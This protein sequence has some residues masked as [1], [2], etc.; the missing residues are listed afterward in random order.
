MLSGG[1]ES[2]VMRLREYVSWAKK[3]AT[4]VSATVRVA[5]EAGEDLASMTTVRVV[6]GN[7]AGD[8]DSMACALV[9]AFYTYQPGQKVPV[10]PVLNVPR[11]ELRLRRDILEVFAVASLAIDELLFVEEVP[12]FELANANKL[13]LTLVDHNELSPRQSNLATAIRAIVDHHQDAALYQ[14][15]VRERN[16]LFPVGSCASLVTEAMLKM[17]RGLQL[18]GDVAVSLLLRSTIMLDT[19][20][21]KNHKTTELDCRMLRAHKKT[22]PTEAITGKYS[23][24]EWH[25]RIKSMRKDIRGFT[26]MDLV[27]KD[28]KFA[29][30]DGQLFAVASAGVSLRDMGLLQSAHNLQ[31]FAGDLKS[32]SVQHHL[33][34]AVVLVSCSPAN[35]QMVLCAPQNAW[36]ML[37]GPMAAAIAS[38]TQYG[39]QALAGSQAEWGIP[40]VGDKLLHE[41]F[42]LTLFNFSASAGR[43]QVL[44]ALKDL[45]ERLQKQNT[46]SL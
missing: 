42:V 2:G 9:W 34:L 27:N 21:L 41:G 28:L 40:G 31:H 16:V 32:F 26:P 39:G 11:E 10:L 23:S 18:I 37:Q 24:K 15:T 43:K 19:K 44:P 17:E 25:K 20:N 12:L 46:A 6:M 4:E 22:M 38:N 36:T 3:A 14:K 8:L 5:R 35:K 7:E 33:V 13:E 29:V 30:V 45:F 1:L